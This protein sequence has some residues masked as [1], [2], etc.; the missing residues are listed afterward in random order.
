MTILPERISS[1][2][3]GAAVRKGDERWFDV[4]RWTHFALVTAEQLQIRSQE[5]AHLGSSTDPDTRRL[6]GL[7]G[8]LGR[9][10]GLSDRWA[11]QVIEQ[12]GKYGELF[13]WNLVPLGIKRGQKALW[14]KGGLQF[15]PPLR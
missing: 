15:S 9:A 12:V 10:F 3:T 5:V 14:T 1:E 13:D 6:L 4:V 8:S 7:E 11:A 2:P